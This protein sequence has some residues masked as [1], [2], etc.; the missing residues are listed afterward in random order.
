MRRENE[1]GYIVVET[2][3]ALQQELHREYLVY[4]IFYGLIHNGI[5]TFVVLDECLLSLY[6]ISWD[7]MYLIDV[8]KAPSISWIF[9]V[10]GGLEQDYLLGLA[11]IYKLIQKRA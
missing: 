3:K 10:L 4:V 5:I 9:L 6:M 1:K 8:T 2:E 11:K 7:C